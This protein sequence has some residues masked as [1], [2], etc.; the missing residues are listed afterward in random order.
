MEEYAEAK[1]T[2]KIT[3]KKVL[4][5]FRN[6]S[7]ITHA[8]NTRV[9]ESKLKN[10]TRNKE[11]SAINDVSFS[12][13]YGAETLTA[14]EAYMTVHNIRRFC[15]HAVILGGTALL[16]GFLINK[17]C[18]SL[19]RYSEDHKQEEVAPATYYPDPIVR[20][21]CVDQKGQIV[22]CLEQ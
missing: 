18:Q 15:K 2:S 4:D 14:S 3:A 11:G 9:K 10:K 5:T 16:S 12:Y 7:S 22:N 20:I 8:R 13:E 19:D 21:Q 6:T 1:R 17:G